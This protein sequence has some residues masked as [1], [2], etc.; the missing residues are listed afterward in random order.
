MTLKD[1]QPVYLEASEGAAAFSTGAVDAWSTWDPFLSV[2]EYKNQ[3]RVIAD[4]EGLLSYNRFY[5]ATDRLA[6]EHPEAFQA[7]FE[8]LV[9]AGSSVQAN[10]EEPAARIATPVGNIELDTL[11]LAPT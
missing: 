9:E 6:R 1:I 3:P 2:E 10:P 7:T 11:T 8:A 4:G 5:M